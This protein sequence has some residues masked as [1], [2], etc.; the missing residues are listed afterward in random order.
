MKKLVFSV[1]DNKVGF[2]EPFTAPSEGLAIRSFGEQA[3][4]TDTPLT[5]YPEDFELYKIGEIDT[6]T[7]EIKNE[8][9]LIATASQYKK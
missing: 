3:S 1:K 9:K 6:E 2:G 5:K 4:N 8:L 7:G